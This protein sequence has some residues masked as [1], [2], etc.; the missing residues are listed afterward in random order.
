MQAVSYFYLASPYSKYHAGIEVAFGIV[1][2]NAALLVQAGIPVYS[3]IAHTHPIAIHGDID[4]LDHSIWLP[5]D[6]PF[7]DA[8]CGL[9][10]C[11]MAGWKDS[12]GVSFE[13]EAFKKA[14]KPIHMMEP[15]IV[16]KALKE[17]PNA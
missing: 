15:G 3:P 1:C 16:P 14:F 4:P 6:K 10:V 9:I 5:A 2:Q 11:Q 8:A 13:I 17:N 12:Y 7:M